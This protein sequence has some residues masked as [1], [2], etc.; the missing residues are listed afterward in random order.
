[1]L[2]QAF[3]RLDFAKPVTH[4]Q[5]EGNVTLVNLPTYYQVRWPAAGYQ[6]GE[7][8]TVTLLGRSV[9]IRPDAQQFTYDFGDGKRLGP[10]A[11]MGGSYP[12]GDVQHLYTDTGS[13]P[14]HVRAAYTGEYRLPGGTWQNIELTVPIDGPAVAVQIKSAHAVLLDQPAG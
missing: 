12:D 9:Q 8:A 14:V 4:V 11:T 13:A 6:P 10:T 3:A 1:M 5:P 2:Q 7:V